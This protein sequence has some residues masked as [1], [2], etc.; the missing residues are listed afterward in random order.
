MAV[1]KKCCCCSLQSGVMVLGILGLILQTIGVIGIISIFVTK[2]E[3]NYGTTTL[4]LYAVSSTVSI[5]TSILLIYGAKNR[6]AGF[7]TPWMVWC[8]IGIVLTIISTIINFNIAGLLVT[9][10]ILLISV[11]CVV[12]VYSLRQEIL[13]N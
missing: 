5:L 2:K 10:V 4:A 3:R 7:L 11:F 8:I 6:K 12:C 13:G 1:L 9:F